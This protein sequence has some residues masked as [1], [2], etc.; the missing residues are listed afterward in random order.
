MK[1]NTIKCVLEFH[2]DYIL[3]LFLKRKKKKG[4]ESCVLELFFKNKKTKK[5]N[6]V[7]SQNLFEKMNARK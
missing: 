2:L 3:D 4:K 7:C 1:E 6:E 5:E